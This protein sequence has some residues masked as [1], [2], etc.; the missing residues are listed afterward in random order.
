MTTF[1]FDDMGSW[2][3]RPV[4]DQ[5]GDEIGAISEIYASQ[6]P[7]WAFIR[8]DRP[9]L[10]GYFV[11]L[12]EARDLGDHVQVPYERAAIEHAPTVEPEWELSPEMEVQL[13]RYYGSFP[14]GWPRQERSRRSGWPR[15]ES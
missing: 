5:D 2:R 10:N 6:Q 15:K 12:H 4:I 8:I 14:T 3:D 1:N 9:D 11:P 7:D 13:Y